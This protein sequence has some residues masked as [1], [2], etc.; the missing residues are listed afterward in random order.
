MLLSAHDFAS[1]K[2][3]VANLKGSNTIC[4]GGL[5]SIETDRREERRN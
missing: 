3:Q 5:R 2:E 1:M 4:I